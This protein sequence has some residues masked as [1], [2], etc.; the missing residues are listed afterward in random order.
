[1]RLVEDWGISSDEFLRAEILQ[2]DGSGHTPKTAVM[3]VELARRMLA[4]PAWLSFAF[5]QDRD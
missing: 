3:K 4:P 5:G 2:A 1:M